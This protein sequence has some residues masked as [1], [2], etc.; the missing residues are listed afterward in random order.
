[1]PASITSAIDEGFCLR[2]TYLAAGNDILHNQMEDRMQLTN[3][4]LRPL[5]EIG[6]KLAKQILKEVATSVPSDTILAWYRKAASMTA[7]QAVEG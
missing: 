4:E 7:R 5:A 1:L 2:Y 6:Q 3:A